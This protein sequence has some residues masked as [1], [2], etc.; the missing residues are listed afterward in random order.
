MLRSANN[1]R[2]ENRIEN[3]P[4]AIAPARKSEPA[5]LLRRDQGQ[6]HISY[7]LHTPKRKSFIR[8]FGGWIADTAKGI[9]GIAGMAAFSSDGIFLS[10]PKRVLF[11]KDTDFYDPSSIKLNA[12]AKIVSGLA[13]IAAYAAY[14][15]PHIDK[16]ADNYLILAG[17]N[18]IGHELTESAKEHIREF[19]NVVTILFSYT[20]VSSTYKYLRNILIPPKK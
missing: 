3:I 15:A 13:V 18:V 1:E 17:Q 11:T 16:F 10:Y 5:Q 12:G 9:G 7:F 20:V 6:D 8:G 2:N 14:V 19:A 4:P